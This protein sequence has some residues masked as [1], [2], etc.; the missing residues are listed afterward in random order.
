MSVTLFKDTTYN[1]TN[2]VDNIKRGEIALPDI[3]RPFVWPASKV[4]DLFDSMYKGFPVGYLLFWYTGAELGARQIGTDAKEAV[5]RLLIVDGQQRLTSLF[6][7]L[8]GTPIV[9]KDYSQGRIRIAFRPADARFEVTDAAIARDPEFIPDITQVWRSYRDTTRAYFARLKEHREEEVD[10]DDEDRLDDAID[11]LKDLAHYPFKAVELDSA[12]DEERVAEIF[13]RINS[14]GVTLNQADFILTLMSVWWDKGRRQL[15]EFSRAAKQPSLR[16]P[17]PFNHFIDPGPD[18]LLRV[19]VGLAFR[20]G[21]LQHVYSLLRGKDLETGIVSPARREAQLA[22]LRQAQDFVLDL[23]NW[24]EFLKCLTRAG[25]RS[26]R[27]ISSENALLYTYALWLVGRRDFSVSLPRLRDVIARWFFMAHTTGRYTTSPESQIEGDF[28]RLRDLAPGDADGFC[29]RLDHEVATA[30]TNDYWTISLPNRLDTAAAKSPALVAY[31]AALNL[32]DAELLFSTSK[33]ATLLDP[34]VTPVKTIERQHLFPK[35]YLE[36]VGIKGSTRTNQIANMAFVDWADNTA[37]S[38]TAPSQYWPE[39]SA[40]LDSQR[41]KAQRYWHALPVGWEQL[42]YDDFLDKRRRLI[43]RVVRDAFQT[44]L[45]ASMSEATRIAATTRTSELITA[46]ES[47]NVEFKSTARWS[48]KGQVKDPKVEHVI[49]KTVVGFMNAEGGTLLIGVDDSGKALGL[50][51]D[52]QTLGKPN[53][54]GYELFLTQLLKANLSGA[55]LTLARVSFSE[56]DGKDVCRIDVAA[57]AQPVFA[58]PLDGKEHSEFWARVGNSTRQLIGT[59]M[60][61]YQRDHWD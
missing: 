34:G 41:L 37:I 61:Q 45:P 33:I 5:P 20:R 13:V 2:L 38:A 25:F 42:N 24:H 15:E 56:I 31:W 16:G 21:R 17:S 60:A 59:D 26:S 9:A 49:V 22:I 30:F 8:T 46:G 50:E 57:S 32:L 23:M 53:R 58:R 19:A 29:A 51:R 39:M 28:N 44:L 48:Y 3:Q 36:S 18:Q 1:L 11:R 55:A 43:A 6:A 10:R 40:R 14:E 27:M 47:V 7:V 52:Y 54:D 35:Q 12:V 4:R